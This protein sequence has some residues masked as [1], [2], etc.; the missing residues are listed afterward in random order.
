MALEDWQTR[1]DKKYSGKEEKMI[2]RVM[3]L[4]RWFH[5]KAPELDE[6]IRSGAVK[7]RLGKDI[8][9]NNLNLTL[10]HNLTL[11]FICPYFY[12]EIGN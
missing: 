3:F 5:G 1:T 2:P 8:C 9:P 10:P 11:S 7:Q 12:V 4:N 6:A